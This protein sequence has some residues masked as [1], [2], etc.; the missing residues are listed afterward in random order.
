MI[1]ICGHDED[2]PT[3][4]PPLLAALRAAV[5]GASLLL[6]GHPGDQEAAY[7]AAGL[8]D[9]VTVKSNNQETN[10]RYLISLGVIS[11]E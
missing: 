1:V 2:Y 7:R 9:F 6:A 11:A 10:R 4:V 8:D 5:P 3:L